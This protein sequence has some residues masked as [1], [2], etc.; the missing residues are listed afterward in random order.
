MV[1]FS[2]KHIWIILYHDEVE[3]QTK[4]VEELPKNELSVNGNLTT[5]GKLLHHQIVFL[6]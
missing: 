2:D 1:L 6:V 5:L 4:L 3:E